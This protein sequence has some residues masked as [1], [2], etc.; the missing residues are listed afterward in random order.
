VFCDQRTITDSAGQIP[1]PDQIQAEVVR[2][3][4]FTQKHHSSIQISF[5][6]GNF[7]G[8]EQKV[9]IELLETAAAFVDHGT[10]DSL[11]FSTRP[12]TISEERLSAIAPYPVK[13]VELGVQ[14]MND[15]VLAACRRGHTAADTIAAAT[16]I[17]DAGY[18][19]GLQMMVGLPG[20]DA[21]GAMA[22]ACRLVH[23][24]PDF[25]RIYPTLVLAGSPLAR[26]LRTGK[27]R[28]VPLNACIR[29]M[30]RL[31]LLFK[32]N[33]IPVIRM[34]LQASDGLADPGALLAGPYHPAFGHLVHGEI[35]L[36]AICRALADMKGRPTTL[37]IRTH[38][39]MVSRV[40]G[41][42]KR[43]LQ[44]LRHHHD[45]KKITLIQDEKIKPNQLMLGNRSI[46]YEN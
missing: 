9:M 33:H 16:L 45:F 40:Q 23:L 39:A 32:A 30:A 18:Q 20:D 10:V 22:T 2:Y 44:Y 12:D 26:M 38:P 21:D 29:L 34:G 41:L 4:T 42:N 28:P 24:N 6:G 46:F 25:V 15:A 7:L 14:S 43:N 31:Y 8:L 36:N 13:T 1:T 37:T 5:F 19:L 27:Y 11:R 17:K 35:V 3:L